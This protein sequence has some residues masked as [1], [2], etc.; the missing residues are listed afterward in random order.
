MLA[1]TVGKTGSLEMASTFIAEATTCTT[2]FHPNAMYSYE[3]VAPVKKRGDVYYR[4]AM[5]TVTHISSKSCN[6][7]L[8]VSHFFVNHLR[9]TC[10]LLIMLQIFPFPADSFRMLPVL[11]PEPQTWN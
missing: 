11:S 6:D 7:I 1:H 4:Q 2:E 10:V 9:H 8:L 3:P 5:E